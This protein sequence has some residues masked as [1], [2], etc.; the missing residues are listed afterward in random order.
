MTPSAFRSPDDA[1]RYRDF[2]DRRL[3]HWRLTP[4]EYAAA[5]CVFAEAPSL[6]PLRSALIRQT[7]SLDME[8][9]DL[10]FRQGARGIVLGVAV[11][12]V[13]V[14]NLAR[15]Y[16][17]GHGWEEILDACG[18]GDLEAIAAARRVLRRSG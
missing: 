7:Q 3:R 17:A 8:A 11:A 5:E 18:P 4:S 1:R 12:A 14:P 6:R 9:L 15:A 13:T 10:E 16:G 2:F